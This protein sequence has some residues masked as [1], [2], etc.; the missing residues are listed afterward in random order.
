[1]RLAGSDGR[2]SAVVEDGGSEAKGRRKAVLG[3]R[4]REG[5][6]EK[7]DREKVLR[8]MML[9]IVWVV[10]MAGVPKVLPNVLKGEPPKVVGGM[11]PPRVVGGMPPPRVG[12]STVP[13]GMRGEV[14]PPGMVVRGLPP[15]M[16][17]K[18]LV[19]PPVMGLPVPGVAPGGRK[20][21]GL[22]GMALG[23]LRG[24]L[25]SGLFASGLLAPGLLTSGLL[26]PGLLV[27][28]GSPL[29]LEPGLDG[30]G[31]GKIWVSV[32]WRVVVVVVK[33]ESTWFL[34]VGVGV[35]ETVISWASVA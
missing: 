11:P 26:T 9:V 32:G 33:D 34:T 30:S 1:M 8:G 31:G 20:V 2:I 17:V 25:A 16:V 13:P 4:K 12:G 29:V 19:P 35:G 23:S 10:I 14:M 28:L 24:L 27:P 22:L 15:G 7:V 18:G 5:V 21:G 3:S 6:V